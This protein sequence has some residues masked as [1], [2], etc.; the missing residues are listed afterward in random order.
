QL[1][2]FSLCII[3]LVL[4]VEIIFTPRQIICKKNL[5]YF[6]IISGL[7]FF[8][9][10]LPYVVLMKEFW[11]HTEPGLTYNNGD[12]KI[13]FGSNPLNPIIGKDN[14]NLIYHLIGSYR[15]NAISLGFS[16]VGL[17]ALALVFRKFFKEKISFIF[18]ALGGIFLACGS[19]FQFNGI[20]HQNIKMPFSYLGNLPFFNIGV[21]PTRF[22]IVAYFACA[23]LA[24]LFFAGI[25][26]LF[27]G[28]LKF[29]SYLILLIATLAVGFEYY[30]GNLKIDKL[31]ISPILYEI[32]DDKGDFTVL[33]FRS[34]SRDAYYQT[35]HQKKAVSG[36][37]GRRIHDYYLLQYRGKPM[38]DYI[39]TGD[40]RWL[41]SDDFD[42]IRVEK[43]FED[44]K[45]R[46]ITV[47]KSI[48]PPEEIKKMQSLMANLGYNVWREDNALIVYKLQ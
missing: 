46:Y 3:I 43:T 34:S 5:W 44:Y 48:S 17:S 24:G 1:L 37:L 12:A 14:L 10:A 42:P 8:I 2:V 45:I 40:E 23:V 28:K 16:V 47:D 35:F 18:V 27:K 29:L 9:F 38:V 32:R 41:A 30:S 20:V 31:T 36:Y 25:S 4:I 11:G 22:I 21:V 19:Y 39:M 26:E 15:E 7:Y 6:L 13:I 33:P